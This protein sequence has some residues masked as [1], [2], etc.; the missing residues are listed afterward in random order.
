MP[1]VLIGDSGRLRQIVVNLIGNALKFTEQGEIVLSVR[2]LSQTDRDVELEFAVRDTGIGIP[3]EKLASIFEAFEQVDTTLT[4]RFG[5]TGLGL[6]ICR[7]LTELMNGRIWVESTPGQGK[8]LSFHRSIPLHHR[9]G[10]A[11]GDD[12]GRAAGHPSPGR[13]RQRNVAPHSD[14]NAAE[15]GTDPH[16]R[17]ARPRS[18]RHAAAVTSDN[19]PAF[20]L[21]VTD[22]SMPDMDGFTLVEQLRED[23]RWRQL[24]RRPADI[25]TRPERV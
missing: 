4:R 10:R 24:A 7:K 23:P 5:G 19:P 11:A 14:R 12:P 22:I 20:D 17:V 2:L 9:R 6:A 1:H 18:T 3:E 16:I 15:L 13:R 21:L 8:R 25:R